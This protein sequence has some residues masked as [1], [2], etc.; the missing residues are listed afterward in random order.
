MPGTG[1]LSLCDASVSRQ[2]CHPYGRRA[3]GNNVRSPFFTSSNGFFVSFL[4]CQPFLKTHDHLPLDTSTVPPLSL[5]LLRPLTSSDLRHHS[6]TLLIRSLI[7]IPHKVRYHVPRIEL[8]STLFCLF[9]PAGQSEASLQSSIHLTLYL[10]SHNRTR[11]HED[12]IQ[13]HVPS[14]LVRPPVPVRCSGSVLRRRF[15][16]PL[17]DPD[18]SSSS[19]TAFLHQHAR[20][21]CH[22][23]L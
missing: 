11:H 20:L 3:T 8:F 6:H 2:T 9:F 12:S 5:T 7:L 4:P 19:Y 23:P 13:N 22:F 10:S 15:H 14:R 21:D 18:P 16:W 17:V 1:L